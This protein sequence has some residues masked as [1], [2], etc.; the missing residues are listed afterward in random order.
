[1]NMA[2]TLKWI[3]TL[4]ALV[5]TLGLLLSRDWRWS[6]ATLALQY[7]G[8][9][10]LVHSHWPLSMAAV[11]LVTGWMVCA[12]LG[13]AL[14]RSG[15][16]TASETAWPQGR[17]FRSLA[18]GLIA[19]A[20]FTLAQKTATWLNISLAMAWGSLLLMGMGLLHLGITAQPL[21]VILGLLTF[22]GGFEIIYA[23]VESSSLVAALLAVIN[24]CLALVGAYLLNAHVAEVA[25]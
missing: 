7:L 13:L 21:R 12:A 24:L 15:A 11:K 8:I 23:A 6:L 10:W 5:T 20:A 25:E 16:H 9:F 2:D 18:G 17:L 1:M 4:L 3:A 19:L 14:H 22:L